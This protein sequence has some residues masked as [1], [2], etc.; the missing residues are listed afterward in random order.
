MT[1]ALEQHDLTLVSVS[2]ES[3]SSDDLDADLYLF[4]ERAILRE[5]VVRS[6]A[7][8]PKSFTMREF[9]RRAQLNPPDRERETFAEWLA[10]I[11]ATRRREE[12]LG[13][14]SEDDVHDPGLG[15]DVGAFD[16][17]IRYLELLSLKVAQFLIGWPSK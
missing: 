14:D 1:Q 3:L 9:A 2:G 8:W 6:P 11:H 5:A 7:L 16:T 15:G 12:L 17:M 13:T 4:M 10:V